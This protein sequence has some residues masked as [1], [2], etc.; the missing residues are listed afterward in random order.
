M[1][2]FIALLSCC[3]FVSLSVFAQKAT[4]FG[5]FDF[6]QSKD[7]STNVAANMFSRLDAAE[8]EVIAFDSETSAML[9]S[10]FERATK[11]RIHQSKMGGGL[12]FLI[13]DFEGEKDTHDVV[14]WGNNFIDFNDSKTYVVENEADKQWLA[15]FRSA[16]CRP[17]S[18]VDEELLD[19]IASFGFKME[20][21]L[22][23]LK[24]TNTADPQY[25][26]DYIRFSKLPS[27][28]T[29][30]EELLSSKAT[31]TIDPKANTVIIRT[32]LPVNLDG[33]RLVKQMSK[34]KHLKKINAQDI[35]SMTI[36]NGEVHLV[37]K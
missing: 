22:D 1:R 23:E 32:Q 18:S 4:S 14:L 28:V 34:R 3:L 5:M 37:L 35:S 13:V 24:K 29:E 8:V 10:I 31:V 36:Q 7:C 11:V 33:K 19:R 27:V 30:N 9:S 16:K 6:V 15:E 20:M 21:A 12:F 25:S 2:K 17:S 26:F